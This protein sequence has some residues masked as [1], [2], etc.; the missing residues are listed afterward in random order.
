MVTFTGSHVSVHLDGTAIVE[1]QAHNVGTM[2]VDQFTLGALRTN[3]NSNYLAGDIAELIVY[4]DA[5]SAADRGR[6]EQ[7]LGNKY[8]ITIA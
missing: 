6:L 3:A 1:T 5:K 8:G 2:T 4:S 7:Y